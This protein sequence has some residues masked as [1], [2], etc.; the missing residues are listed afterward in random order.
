[1][2]KDYCFL[3][4]VGPD[5]SENNENRRKTTPTV[6]GDEGAD[7]DVVFAQQN[8]M[9]RLAGDKLSIVTLVFDRQN[10]DQLDEPGGAA[11]GEVRKIHFFDSGQ[12][13]EF[14]QFWKSESVARIVKSVPKVIATTVT[15]R[16]RKRRSQHRLS[17]RHLHLQK[18]DLYHL[19]RRRQQF[20]L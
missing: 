4:V 6:D 19:R 8:V 7:V 13:Q 3:F 11:A 16:A 14:D 18:L 15:R 2:S 5:F 12:S 20:F 1:M 17:R 9:L 10:L